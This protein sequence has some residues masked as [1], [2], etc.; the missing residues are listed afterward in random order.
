MCTNV[1]WIDLDSPH[2]EPFPFATFDVVNGAHWRSSR[3]K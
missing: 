3:S 2:P 1:M